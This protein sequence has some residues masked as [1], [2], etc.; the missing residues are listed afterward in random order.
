M[1]LTSDHAEAG[2]GL[3]RLI[4]PMSQ[5][6]FEEEYLDR[7]PL[8][9]SRSD[10]KYYADLLTFDDLDRLLTLS[11]PAFE[12][13]RV[14]S[15]SVDTLIV[16]GDGRRHEA[17]NRLEA[18]Y[19]HYRAGSTLV[20]NSMNERLEPLKR[21][22]HVLHSELNA[23][24]EMNVYLTPG[25]QAQGFKPHYD[26]HDVFVLQVHGTKKWQLYGCPFPM[27]LPM[28]AQEF[29]SLGPSLNV[30]AQ[31]ERE[32]EMQPGDLLYLP[33]GTVHAATSNATAT[34]HLTIGMHRPLWF[35]LIQEALF[36]LCAKDVRLRA[37]LPVGFNRSEES[38]DEATGTLRELLGSLLAG[39]RP[40][41]IVSGAASRTTFITSPNLRGHLNDLEQVNSLTA[42]T[43]L[44]RREGIRYNLA[45]AGQLIRLEFHNKTVE[46]PV[47][48]APVV[49][50]LV[51][52]DDQ[53]FTAAD[54]PEGLGLNVRLEIVRTLLREGFLT[55]LSP[56]ETLG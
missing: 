54:I 42:D 32:I 4:D 24:F 13:V 49:Q 50:F 43:V 52:G 18:I 34:A 6:E 5:Q 27:P 14:V 35:P 56:A 53:G 40:E 19:R 15:G 41:R 1:S 38:L 12:N 55:T 48:I 29:H 47:M 17:A 9:I 25:G 3:A 22:E 45:V 20:L 16:N 30:P 46:L 33:R 44:Y 10:E 26:T 37:A 28:P 21:L 36:E 11:G 23:G 7:K 39:L 8:H 51:N 31:A 2:L